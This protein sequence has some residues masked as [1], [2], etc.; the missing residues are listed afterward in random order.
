VLGPPGAQEQAQV[1]QDWQGCQRGRVEAPEAG[2][3]AGVLR[4]GEVGVLWRGCC[5]CI[6]L[7]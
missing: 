1:G 2:P 3:A 5:G 7:G 4:L 6:A